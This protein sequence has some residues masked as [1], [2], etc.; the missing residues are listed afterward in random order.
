MEV[1]W[2][3]PNP[4][5]PELIGVEPAEARGWGGCVKEED[6]RMIAVEFCSISIPFVFGMC[7]LHQAPSSSSVARLNGPHHGSAMQFA[8]SELSSIFIR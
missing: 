2:D 3:N 7:K 6:G 8:L 4:N 5:A 1:P